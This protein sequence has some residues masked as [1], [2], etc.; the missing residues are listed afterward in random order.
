VALAGT[1]DEVAEQAHALYAAGAARVEFGTP[2]GL[3]AR[4]GLRLL[5]DAV[6]PAL[7]ARWG[8][9]RG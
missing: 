3:D 7:R 6:L 4:E 1:P 2:H 9:A 5:G 8:V